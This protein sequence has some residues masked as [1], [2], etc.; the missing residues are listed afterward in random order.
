MCAIF[1]PID[2]MVPADFPM[3]QLDVYDVR[4]RHVTLTG[5]DSRLT[6]AQRTEIREEASLRCVGNFSTCGS[7]SAHTH[8]S[9]P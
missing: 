1:Y 2:G 5:A 8:F 9:N 7:N 3:F 6:F 4:I